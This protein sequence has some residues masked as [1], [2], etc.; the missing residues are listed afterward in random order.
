MIIDEFEFGELW[1]SNQG[2]GRKP[3]TNIGFGG[4]THPPYSII[5]V[6]QHDLLVCFIVEE[7]D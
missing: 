4:E 3:S 6:D 2:W 1:A 7:N 5:G